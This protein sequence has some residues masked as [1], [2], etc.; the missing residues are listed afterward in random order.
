MANGQFTV[1]DIPGAFARGQQFKHQA[2]IRPLEIAAAQ[3]A[4][5]GQ[6]QQQKQQ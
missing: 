6:Q 4:L 5:I 2:E 3:Q 1:A